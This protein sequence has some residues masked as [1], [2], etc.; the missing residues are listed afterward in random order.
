MQYSNLLIH[1]LA[2]G[3]GTRT[4]SELNGIAKRATALGASGLELLFH[5]MPVLP[6]CEVAAVFK[7]H[8]LARASLCLFYPE[9]LSCG[10]PTTKEGRELALHHATRAADYVCLLQDNGIDVRVID[11][12]V[13]IVL[14]R[15]AKYYAKDAFSETLIFTEHLAEIAE[16]AGVTF[17]SEVLQCSEDGL[18]RTSKRMEELVVRGHSCYPYCFEGH[19]DTFHFVKNGEKLGNVFRRLNPF[20]GHLHCNGIGKNRTK[21]GRIPCGCNDFEI[22]GRRY[23]D[24]IDWKRVRRQLEAVVM[25]PVPILICLEPFHEEACKAIPPLRE[26]VVPVTDDSQ[27]AES[28]R[29]L[30]AAGLLLLPT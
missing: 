27:I 1:T 16:R 8:G 20:I 25:P 24:T 6:A 9:D 17:C 19:I 21:E 28:V 13:N 4:V 3:A 18:V 15:K 22:N 10:D 11:G 23:T 30:A 14:G 12:P 29:N 5:P 26:G 7:R 2:F